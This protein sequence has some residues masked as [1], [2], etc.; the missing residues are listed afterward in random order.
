VCVLDKVEGLEKTI[1]GG[2]WKLIKI[3]HMN[4][5]YISNLTQHASLLTRSKSHSYRQAI[6][7]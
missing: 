7:P 1:I 2:E 5:T 4:L 3:S 6:G